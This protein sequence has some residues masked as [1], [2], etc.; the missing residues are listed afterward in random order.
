MTIERTKERIRREVKMDLDEIPTTLK[1]NFKE[2]LE[3]DDNEAKI[4]M[5]NVIVYLSMLLPLPYTLAESGMGTC[6]S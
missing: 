6:P 2:E 5:L 1:S 4:I 3:G